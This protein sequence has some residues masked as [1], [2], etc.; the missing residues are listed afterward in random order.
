MP[1]LPVSRKYI[2]I[3]SIASMHVYMLST[4][5]YVFTLNVFT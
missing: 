3:N 2:K 1:K 4:C 5:T